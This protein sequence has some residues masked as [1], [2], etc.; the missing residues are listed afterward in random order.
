M[1]FFW[2]PK[3]RLVTRSGVVAH[4][5]CRNFCALAKDDSTAIPPLA[6]I[7]A[8]TS[9]PTSFLE[10]FRAVRQGRG[11]RIC[12]DPQKILALS[13]SLLAKTRPH[14]QN[15][16]YFVVSSGGT[17]GTPKQILRTQ[18]SWIRSFQV[19][20][21]LWPINPGERYGLLGDIVHSITLY[22]ALEGLYL[23]ADVHMLKPFLP[24]TQ[25]VRIRELGISLIY[26][27]PVQLNLLIRAFAGH[28]AKPLIGISTIVVG[29]SKLS[30]VMHDQLSQVFPEAKIIEFYGSTEA[31]FISLASQSTP[32]NSVGTPYPHTMVRILDENDAPLPC[33]E[34]GRIAVQSPFCASGFLTAK[35]FAPFRQEMILTGEI[36]CFD[37][38]DNL[39]IRGRIDRMIMSADVNIHPEEIETYLQQLPNVEAAYVYPSSDRLRGQQMNACVFA[40]RGRISKKDIVNRCR[41]D[42]GD[43]KTPKSIQLIDS[44]PPLL[45]SGK[46]DLKT[47]R[48]YP[49]FRP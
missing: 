23:G 43:Q 10:L 21:E 20:T 31:S 17:A 9:A 22:G 14:I 34:V 41:Q 47:L 8:T 33:E 48:S 2:H 37:S 4:D 38:R 36:G 32:R 13:E 16:P 18:Q 1:E 27:T 5:D 3:S 42:L 6:T 40:T 25:L 26:A 30:T 44:S 12:S 39:Y 28:R 11:F 24:Q 35:G 15:E 45:P 7:R 46:L 49:D 19:N 29:G